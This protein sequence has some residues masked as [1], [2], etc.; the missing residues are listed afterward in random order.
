MK[1][2]ILEPNNMKCRPRQQIRFLR[3]LHPMR[4][5]TIFTLIP[6]FPTLNIPTESA[7]QF[8]YGFFFI[9]GGSYIYEAILYSHRI[10][11]GLEALYTKYTQ[12]LPIEF[13]GIAVFALASFSTNHDLVFW[14]GL[15][16]A[17]I[18]FGLT[19]TLELFNTYLM[20]RLKNVKISD[21]A[22]MVVF[23]G[24]VVFFVFV[25]TYTWLIAI[26]HI[27]S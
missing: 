2:P 16:I 26:E 27:N 5:V 21:Q 23:I 3:F 1:Y 19:A 14:E 7:T 12:T 11:I 8:M 20:P 13:V 18:V 17:V 4:I 9:F 6:L 22:G 15:K 10:R 24:A 25:W